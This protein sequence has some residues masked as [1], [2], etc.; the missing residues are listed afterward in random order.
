V[1]WLWKWNTSAF[2]PASLSRR[3]HRH[4]RRTAPYA[5]GCDMALTVSVAVAVAVLTPKRRS[6]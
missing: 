6:P 4:Q 3:L 5:G 2:R 1:Q